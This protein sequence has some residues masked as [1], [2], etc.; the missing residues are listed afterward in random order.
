MYKVLLQVSRKII[1]KY[2]WLSLF[3]PATL[4]KKASNI[5]VFLWILQ[6]FQDTYFVKY[7]RTAASEC[8]WC[9]NNQ[10]QKL[11]HKA[12][13][14]SFNVDFLSFRLARCTRHPSEQFQIIYTLFQHSI[15]G[16]G[17][18]ASMFFKVKRGVPQYFVTV[19]IFK[20]LNANT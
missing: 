13:S 1:E 4:L 16:M 6:N 2:F 10:P 11:W 17:G 5:G 8:L 19:W 9:N 18:A 3:R 12:P 7:L 14:H 20:N 15:E